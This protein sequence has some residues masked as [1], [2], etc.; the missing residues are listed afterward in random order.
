MT[1]GLCI[2]VAQGP[3]EVDNIRQGEGTTGNDPNKDGA[4]MTFISK[5]LAFVPATEPGVP[6]VADVELT[7][8]EWIPTATAVSNR[9]WKPA[10]GGVKLSR[11][12]IDARNNLI[13][14]D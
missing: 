9:K 10:A 6:V 2:K 8:G 1:D 13:R 12:T 11:I 14:F 7:M 3:A 5:V 4:G